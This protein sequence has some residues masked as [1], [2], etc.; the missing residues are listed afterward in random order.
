MRITPWAERQLSFGK[1][2]EE[3]P[4]MLERVK[5]TTARLRNLTSH[6]PRER[7]LLRPYGQ[8]SVVDHIG[9]LIYLQDRSEEH[10]D[11]FVSRR[12]ELCQID[13]SDQ[14]SILDLHRRQEL[15]D[16]I[17]EFRLKRDYFVRRI[18]DMDPGAL[19]HQALNRCRGVRMTIVDT[20]LYVAEHDDHHL[21]SM[22]N[23]L[24]H[25]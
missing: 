12:N 14:A 11:D 5:G 23:I 16:L 21:A 25:D 9:H 1:G 8:W 6:V 18:Q 17:E 7:L 22:R 2:L 13:L 24:I 20:I 19:R 3:L 4:V 10:V 15:G